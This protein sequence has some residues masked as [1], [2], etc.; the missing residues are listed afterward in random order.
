VHLHV[1]QA[2]LMA[3]Y[4]LHGV[5]VV[6]PGRL[7]VAGEHDRRQQ[8]RA[9]GKSLFFN[10]LQSQNVLKLAKVKKIIQFR[11][12]EHYGFIGLEKCTGNIR[13]TNVFN[14]LP[15][16]RWIPGFWNPGNAQII[17]PPI[18]FNPPG[19]LDFMIFGKI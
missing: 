6:R 12:R 10:S 4:L 11:K 9:R 13:K 16:R 8:V 15:N 2:A 17:V 3:Q 14:L 5:L 19:E 7:R 18:F 1:L